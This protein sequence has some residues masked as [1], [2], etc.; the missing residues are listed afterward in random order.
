[1]ARTAAISSSERYRRIAE[2]KDQRFFSA[3]PLLNEH[4]G[5]RDGKLHLF[6]APTGAGKS[7]LTRSL[8]LDSLVSEGNKFK[9]GVWL[10]EET[11]DEFVTEINHID[12]PD[13]ISSR[14][15]IESEQEMKFSSVEQWMLELKKFVEENG[16]DLLFLDNIT[17][18]IYYND[19][20]AN[21]QGRVVRS[22]KRLAQIMDIPIVILAHTSSEITET[23][24]RLINLEN[25]RG[26]K[27]LPNMVEFAYIIQPFIYEGQKHTFV[28]IA[29]HRGQDVKE[30]L[31][32]FY[33]YSSKKV[34]G[35]CEVKPWEQFKELFNKRERL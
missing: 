34:Y 23:Y 25:I 9:S 24:P 22:L 2:A 33:Y 19:A 1:M 27:N 6:V 21:E 30:R 11:I 10:T 17:T 16:L 3:Y 13:K 5:W 8:L 4:N 26:S 29:K 32:K 14:M 7:T 15:V 18:S 35:K 31:F 28:R 20:K 12:M